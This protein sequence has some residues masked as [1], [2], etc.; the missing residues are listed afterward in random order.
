MFI[1]EFGSL[2]VLALV[3]L[4]FIPLILAQKD[5]ADAAIDREKVEIEKTKV[6]IDAK[7]KGVKLA[8][9]KVEAD[10][11]LNLDILKTIKGKQ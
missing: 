2:A 1:L 6:E 10:N 8:K 4:F 9:E 11:K 5:A 7:E 3:N